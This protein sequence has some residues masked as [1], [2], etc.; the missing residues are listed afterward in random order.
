MTFDK[1]CDDYVAEIESDTHMIIKDWIKHKP[2]K[3]ILETHNISVKKYYKIINKAKECG[4]SRLPKEKLNEIALDNTISSI[5]RLQE[6]GKNIVDGKFIYH[7][8]QDKISEKSDDDDTDD[9]T[10]DTDD[11][12]ESITSSSNRLHTADI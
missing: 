1:L 5:K 7:E 2:V 9:D 6:R 10:D 8:H 4:I 11:D 3:K 12:T